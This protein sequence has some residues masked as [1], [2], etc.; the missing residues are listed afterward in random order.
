MLESRC[1]NG[2]GSLVGYRVASPYL[3]ERE[4][5]ARH[6]PPID[7][8]YPHPPVDL[9]LVSILEVELRAEIDGMVART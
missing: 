3:V 4:H 1:Q 5:L 8:R 2:D 9:F 6:L 7:E